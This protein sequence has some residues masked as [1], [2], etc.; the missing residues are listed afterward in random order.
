MRKRDLHVQRAGNRVGDHKENE[1][2]PV[3]VDRLVHDPVSEPVPEKDLAGKLEMSVPPRRTVLGCLALEKVLPR[4]TIEVQAGEHHDDVV[5]VVLEGDEEFGSHVV[6]HDTVVV[7]GPQVGEET[8][9]DGEE[10]QMFDIRIVLGAVGDDVVHVM[11]ALPPAQTQT[12][13]EVGNDYTNDSVDVEMVRDTHVTRVVS[14]KDQLMP[15]G[16]K[17]EGARNVPTPFQKQKTAGEEEGIAEP[18]DGI[19]NVV[20]V[21]ES[22]DLDALMKL[23]ILSDDGILGLLVKGRVLVEIESDLL[24][25]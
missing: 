10:G 18:L 15:E 4:E 13:D 24:P 2:V 20:A 3:A 23:T 8:V 17:T 21:I 5:E 12:T 1:A 14:S 9:R 11:V 16:A 19:S 7:G 25:R 22:F 6:L